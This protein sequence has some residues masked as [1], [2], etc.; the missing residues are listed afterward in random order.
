MPKKSI[1]NHKNKN[2]SFEMK[3]TKTKVSTRISTRTAI[4]VAVALI[5]AGA[6]AYGAAKIGSTTTSLETIYKGKIKVING[7]NTVNLCDGTLRAAIAKY[8]S[9]GYKGI[10]IMKNINGQPM[11]VVYTKTDTKNNRQPNDTWFYDTASKTFKIA[12]QGSTLGASTAS[13]C[14]TKDTALTQFVVS[15]AKTVAATKINYTAL[16]KT[17]STSSIKKSGSSYVMQNMDGKV[18]DQTQCTIIEQKFKKS[19]LMGITSI[20]VNPNNVAVF[21][22]ISGVG[23]FEHVWSYNAGSKSY[24]FTPCDPNLGTKCFGIRKV[25]SGMATSM[26]YCFTSNKKAYRWSETTEAAKAAGTQ[27]IHIL[28]S[29]GVKLAGSKVSNTSP[30]P[31]GGDDPYD[32]L[33]KNK[34][35]IDALKAGLAVYY[36]KMKSGSGYDTT[37]YKVVL[38]T[39]SA[40]YPNTWI[41]IFYKSGSTW[42][43]DVWTYKSGESLFYL[44]NSG[45][46]GGPEAEG[47][48]SMMADAKA[49]AK[50][51]TTAPVA[52]PAKPTAPAKSDKLPVTTARN[53]QPGDKAT[54]D[55]FYGGWVCGNKTNMLNYLKAMKTKLYP[56]ESE[57]N[58]PMAYTYSD[59]WSVGRWGYNSWSCNDNSQIRVVYKISGDDSWYYDDWDLYV[60]GDTCDVGNQ[61]IKSKRYKLTNGI[62][63]GWPKGFLC[64]PGH[65]NYAAGDG[66]L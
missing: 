1:L 5:G 31:S 60:P 4:I 54:L 27:Q 65:S 58:V 61:W 25:T 34:Q 63:P 14:N 55:T 41:K 2:N 42:K 32:F 33:C 23:V 28:K 64:Y 20:Y 56:L 46:K 3:K 44:S 62:D 30:Y 53:I 43:Y 36:P 16:I 51:K 52:T 66:T 11:I 13:V 10:Q 37:N 45:I 21:F 12:S 29:G 49:A 6:L 50:A 19:Y 9:E 59:V 48:S 24:T 22:N 15:T 17:D 39:V 35:P 18:D 7:Q 26:D 57:Y 47:C 8:Y 40:T 38:S